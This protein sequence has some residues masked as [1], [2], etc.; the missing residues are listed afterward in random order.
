[1]S[2]GE[3]DNDSTTTP[4]VP[5][6]LRNRPPIFAIGE[7]LND[8]FEILS[9]LGQGGMG[10]VFEARDHALDR[11]VA[12]KAAWPERPR[13][14][15]L[16]EA[17]ALAAV[18]HPSM[19]SV[20]HVGTHRDIDYFVMERVYGVSLATHM[21]RRR[22]ANGRFTIDEVI[23]VLIGVAEGV[24]TVHRAGL[25]HRDLKPANVML[26]PG[27]RVVLM[28]FGLVRPEAE[29]APESTPAG[30]PSYMAPEAIM[31]ASRAGSRFSIDLYALGIIA[32]EMLTLR[33]PFSGATTAE[34]WSGHLSVDV[35]DPRELR[36][37][38][39]SQLATLCMS[40]MAKRAEDR[41]ESVESV[42]ATL[43]AL[44]GRG[45]RTGGD[46]LFIQIVDDDEDMTA[47]LRGIVR[48]SFPDAA[49][50]TAHDAEQAIK[51]ILQQ[52]PDVLLLDLRMPKTN[53]IELAMYVR[54]THI[55]DDTTI[56][57][58]SAR[59]GD[60][61]LALLHQLGITEFVPKGPELAAR[62]TPVLRAAARTS[63][64]GG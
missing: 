36:P 56:I 13:G 35:P 2:E 23:D 45:T 22:A 27:N 33:A 25:A 63:R 44:K 4:A 11:R 15:L 37:D 51:Q 59:A 60:D 12:I 26:A 61:D 31:L 21:T 53:G 41:A 17:R 58:V 40:L 62:L 29:P 49:I 48:A 16:R 52:P 20:L 14:M 19:V 43:R 47:L 34:V 64:P 38:V 1:M 50:A 8:N 18:R 46:S 7:R 39:P 55:A 6:S 24:A 57:A 5:R 54:G 10:Q 9:V 28:D 32:Y 30:T 42:L 3:L